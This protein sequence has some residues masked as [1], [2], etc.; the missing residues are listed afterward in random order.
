MLALMKEKGAAAPFYMPQGDECEVFAAFLESRH[1]LLPDDEAL[2]AEVETWSGRREPGAAG[3][4]DIIAACA[5]HKARVVG[6]D[7]RD[8]GG[9]RAMLNYGHTFGHALESAA[10]FGTLLHGE[11]VAVGMMMAARL[12]ESMGLAQ[13]GL[14]DVHRRLLAPLLAAMPL[15]VEVD[16]EELLVYMRSDKKRGKGERFVLLEGPQ[17]PRLVEDVPRELV[18]EAVEDIVEDIRSGEPWP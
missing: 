17:A 18:N 7:E 1:S 2:L 16:A 15:R 12:S 10:G 11:A 6:E 5:V 4:E 13:G 14:Y 3:L 8:V 9:V